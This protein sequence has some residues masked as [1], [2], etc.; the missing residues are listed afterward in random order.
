MSSSIPGRP[1][2]YPYATVVEKLESLRGKT[3]EHGLGDGHA[4]ER[5][6]ADLVERL[7]T[8]DGFRMHLPERYHLDISRSFREDGLDAATASGVRS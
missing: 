7:H 6:V 3:W 4:S 1:E 2:D 8:P 5:V